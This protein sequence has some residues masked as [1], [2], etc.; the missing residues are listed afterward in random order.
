MKLPARSCV[1]VWHVIAVLGVR[2][3]HKVCMVDAPWVAA[4]VPHFHRHLVDRLGWPTEGKCDDGVQGDGERLPVVIRAE[5]H[6]DVPVGVCSYV[7]AGVERPG[8]GRD[9]GPVDGQACVGWADRQVGALGHDEPVAE[10][11]QAPGCM[12]GTPLGVD[13]GE[14][15]L[16]QGPPHGCSGGR[17][18][19]VLQQGPGGL[20]LQPEGKAGLCKVVH[21]GGGVVPIVGQHV[22]C[23]LTAV[24]H[25]LQVLLGEDEV[26]AISTDLLEG[27]VLLYCFPRAAGADGR[28]EHKH[29]Q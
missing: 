20:V 1:G 19:E 10:V 23:L 8:C 16:Q 21:S 6:H 12:H 18:H 14:H 17:L 29:R 22:Q 2:A 7:V 5:V 11:F 4:Q 28:G 9:G 3:P 27:L 13:K 15:P 24:P 25:S 26:I